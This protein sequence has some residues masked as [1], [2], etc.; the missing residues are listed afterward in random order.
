M[1]EGKSNAEVEGHH[2]SQGNTVKRLLVKVGAQKTATNTTSP[3]NVY[4]CMW[5]LSKFNGLA[6]CIVISQLEQTVSLKAIHFEGITGLFYPSF[7]ERTLTKTY[8][9]VLHRTPT[10]NDTPFFGYLVF[11]PSRG[12]GRLDSCQGMLT[13]KYG[14]VEVNGRKLLFWVPPSSTTSS[15]VM[16]ILQHGGWQ[17]LL[18]K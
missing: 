2:Y 9:P 10:D 11:I 7:R 1:V 13:Q 16:Y 12:L 5:Q 6:V 18:R 17:R 4:L 15:S 14:S 3:L 8:G